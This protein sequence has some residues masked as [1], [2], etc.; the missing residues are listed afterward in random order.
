[1]LPERSAVGRVHAVK[2]AIG[3]AHVNFPVAD[4]GRSA[5]RAFGMLLPDLPMSGQ[6]DRV[7]I[8]RRAADV[9]HPRDDGRRGV[10]A[11]L[12]EFEFPEQLR[13]I[14]QRARRD[15]RGIRV[16][17]KQRP[18]GGGGSQR[19]FGLRGFCVR[20]AERRLRGGQWPADRK[21][22]RRACDG[23]HIDCWAPLAPPAFRSQGNAALAEPAADGGEA[24][25]GLSN[26]RE[27]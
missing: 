9:N 19:A 12:R 6:I 22:G 8:A 24:F 18:A 14:R 5:E 25:G 15:A 3:V 13:L 4:G 27:H 7:K 23:Q 2:L 11:A 26:R 17:T 21:H 1:M 20:A 10:E 16:A